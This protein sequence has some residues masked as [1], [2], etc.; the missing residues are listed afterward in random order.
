MGITWTRRTLEFREVVFFLTWRDIKVRYKQ[1][2]LGALW[3]ILQPLLTM[4]IF[5]VI[6][7]N[8]SMFPATTSLPAILLLRPD[9]LDVLLEWRM[10][11]ASSWWRKVT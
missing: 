2:V 8:C 1:T 6:F 5:S 10:P 3:A 4:V 11:G 9:S 7:G